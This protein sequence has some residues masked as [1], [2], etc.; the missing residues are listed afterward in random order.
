MTSEPHRRLAEKQARL[1]VSILNGLAMPEGARSREW[2][3]AKKELLARAHGILGYLLLKEASF[4]EAA[5][6]TTD[7]GKP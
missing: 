1:G 4:E 6:V 5:V 2:L 7:C 3:D